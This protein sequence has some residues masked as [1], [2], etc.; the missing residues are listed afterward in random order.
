MKYHKNLNKQSIF[1]LCHEIT[2]SKAPI[3]ISNQDDH[4][5]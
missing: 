4:Q 3:E 2:R 5:Y 1:P